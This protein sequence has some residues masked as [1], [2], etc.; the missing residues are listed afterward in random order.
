MEALIVGNRPLTKSVIELSKNKFIIAADGG[1]DRL[2]EFNFANKI[3]A[4]LDSLSKKTAT[5]LKKRLVINKKNPEKT[6]LEKAVDYATEKGNKKIKIIGWSGG[7]IDHTIGALGLA[8]NPNIELIDDNFT[9]SVVTNLETISGKEGTLFSLIGM[10]DAKVSVEGAKWNLR[11]QKLSMSGRGI[12]NEG[13]SEKVTVKCHAEIY[14][15]LREILPRP[16]LIL[17]QLIK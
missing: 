12:H 13:N 11:E 3:V 8:F 5:D 9:I 14:C 4:D 15:Y 1:G 7:R 17:F 2:L 6:D 16:R 10:P